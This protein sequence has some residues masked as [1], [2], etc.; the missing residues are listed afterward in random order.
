MK[1][2]SLNQ[3]KFN[4]LQEIGIETGMGKSGYHVAQARAMTKEPN[5]A[6]KFIVQSRQKKR[7]QSLSSA[8][9]SMEYSLPTQ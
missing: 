6:Q 2:F 8:S 5:A 3:Y 7:N 9:E 4:T 1:G